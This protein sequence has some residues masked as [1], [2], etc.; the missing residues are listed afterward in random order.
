MKRKIGFT[1]FTLAEV[2]I[3]LGII[4]VVAALTI[5]SLLQKA[6]D[7]ARIEALKKAY[8]TISNAYNLAINENGTAETWDL[9]GT[10][11]PV[12]A[13]TFVDKLVP[14][15][16]IVSQINGGSFNTVKL[17]DGSEFNFFVWTANCSSPQS[18]GNVCGTIY[19]I[20]K[21]EKLNTNGKNVF[22]FWV[23]KNKILPM[24][25]PSDTSYSF[26]SNCARANLATGSDI[27]GPSTVGRGCTAWALQQDNMDYLYC[28]GLSWNG[29][30]KCP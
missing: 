18:V 4:G 1:G 10:G 20:V 12:G 23:L 15:M 14:Y 13:Q 16:K 27:T 17:Q 25:I 21:P 22:W 5:P 6:N 2:L 7:R 28:D 19:Y 3:T 30:S 9:T 26:A 8:S 24:G 29:P 11:S